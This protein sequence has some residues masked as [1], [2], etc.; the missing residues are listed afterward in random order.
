[1]VI[2]R[3][4]PVVAGWRY[5]WIFTLHGNH[6]GESPQEV[7]FSD[8]IKINGSLLCFI[9]HRLKVRPSPLCLFSPQKFFFKKI[10]FYWRIIALQ[11]FVVFCQTITW[12]CHR[13]MYI[14]FILN[15]LPI[16]LPILPLQVDIEPCFEFPEAHSKFP[17]AI[18]F[19]Y[20]NVSFH[21]TLSIHLTLSSPIPMS[22][23]LFLYVCFSTAVLQIN[24]LVPFSR[25][26]ICVLEYDI[27]LCLSDSFHSV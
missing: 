22:I 21:V 13:Y 4:S 27:Y 3:L 8:S 23:S 18:Y 16:S 1:M 7:C 11:N 25:F 24:S 9:K 6:L 19:T 5:T 10:F 2:S 15:F 20:G 26:H 14:P 12:I 17:L